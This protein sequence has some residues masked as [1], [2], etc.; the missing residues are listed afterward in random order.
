MLRRQELRRWR[1]QLVVY[2][3]KSMLRRTESPSAL[4]D[5]AEERYL[6][7]V[8]EREVEDV[9]RI[10]ICTG[11]IGHEL[12]AERSRRGDSETAIVFLDQLYPFPEAE[13]TA[14]LARYAR[15]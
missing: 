9:R 10:V 2:T 8:P 13:L 7:V 1:K 11:K 3:L 14:E 6:N 15:A 5:F 12:R 4:A